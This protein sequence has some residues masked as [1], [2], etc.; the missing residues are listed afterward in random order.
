MLN[1]D[2]QMKILVDLSAICNKEFFL[3]LSYHSNDVQ[4]IQLQEQDNVGYFVNDSIQDFFEY[5][6]S[7][8]QFNKLIF[9]LFA[10]S[11]DRV[12]DGISPQRKYPKPSFVRIGDK[13]L[14]KP[15]L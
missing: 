8:L 9:A 14:S 2:Q 13:A 3:F 5:I 7:L 1:K 15:L 11:I 6:S 10:S 12:S 4:K